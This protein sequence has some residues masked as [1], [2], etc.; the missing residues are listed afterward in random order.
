[1]A[2]VVFGPRLKMRRGKTI[3]NMRA[4]LQRAV[5]YSFFS[6]AEESAASAQL[7]RIF[8]DKIRV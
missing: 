2:V 8:A 6:L 7:A 1:M 5:E 3:E 4:A